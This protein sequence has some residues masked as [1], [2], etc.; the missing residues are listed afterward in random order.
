MLVAD[1]RGADWVHEWRNR[2]FYRKATANA[3]ANVVGSLPFFITGFNE[4]GIPGVNFPNEFDPGTSDLTMTDFFT[5]SGDGWYVHPAPGSYGLGIGNDGTLNQSG[6]IANSACINLNNKKKV[7]Y[8][9]VFRVRSDGEGNAGRICEAAGS[10]I[11]FTHNGGA[12][13][14]DVSLSLMNGGWGSVTTAGQPVIYDFWHVLMITVDENQAVGSRGTIYLNGMDVTGVDTLGANIVD[15]GNGLTLLNEQGGVNRDLDGVIGLFCVVPDYTMTL[16][17]AQA[18]V[19]LRG[20]FQPTVAD[21]PSIPSPPGT[22]GTPDYNFVRAEDDHLNTFQTQPLKT[23]AGSLMLAFV[24]RNVADQQMLFCLSTEGDANGDVLGLALRG[25]VANDPFE[26]SGRTGGAADL[27][28]RFPSLGLNIPHVVWITSDG[29]TLRAYV[30]GQEQVV[31][32]V[33][34][35]NTGQWF[36]DYA[37][38]TVAVAGAI[39]E[40]VVA[41]EADM[42]TPVLMAYDREV[43]YLDIQRQWAA[44]WGPR[45][46]RLIFER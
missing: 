38:T 45:G 41:E 14:C 29:T 8:I 13:G 23:Q 40:A 21:Q 32:A 28:L 36:A 6:L 3:I 27:E 4:S 25:D 24:P 1:F 22:W 42:M 31:T 37:S 30:N 26:W 35:A 17:N 33:T 20:L 43:S 5:V 18:L 16:A 15:P 2:A 7:T 9:V 44:G 19:E 10:Q 46:P 34:G 11:L 39:R 12:T